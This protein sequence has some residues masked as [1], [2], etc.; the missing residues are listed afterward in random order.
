MAAACSSSSN[1]RVTAVKA[2][3]PA[4]VHD[5]GSTSAT[6]KKAAFHD[7]MRKLWEDHITWTRLY[8]VSAEA[9]LPD[10]DATLQRLL[11]NQTDLGNSIKPFY[12]DAAGAQLTSLLR[13]HILIAG[14]LVAAAMANDTANVATT[15][16]N[17]YANA[18]QIGDFL[19]KANPKRWPAAEMRQ[20]MHEHLDNTLAEAVDHLK[21]DSAADIAD[22]DKVHVQILDMADMLSSGIVAQFPQQFA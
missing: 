5:H 16:D 4:H 1:D 6:A 22:Y 3:T 18:D 10:T 15:R 11:Q 19:G 13:D 9:G 17:W 12:G 7:D 8:I 20:M 2:T 14:D 21:G